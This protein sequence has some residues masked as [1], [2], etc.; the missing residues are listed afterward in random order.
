MMMSSPT[1]EQRE[2]IN[3]DNSNILV[4][5]GAGSGKTFVLKER[6]LRL[7][8]TKTTVDK[9][10]I[11]TFTKNAAAEMKE[12]IRKIILE[13]D[14][15]K[16]QL[17]LVDSAYITTFD[18]FA[19]SIVKKYNYLLNI[20][21]DFGII[22]ANIV[23]V[24]L[25]K[26]IDDIF[27][28]YYDKDDEE[29]KEL[30]T[31]YCYKNDKDLKESIISMYN[32]LLN[33]IDRDEYLDKYIE[34][35]FSDNYINSLMEE[36][37]NNIFNRIEKL[38]PLYDELLELTIKDTAKESNYNRFENIKN[39]TTFDELLES[40]S[41]PIARANKGWYEDGYK[42]IKASIDN[43]EKKIKEELLHN[44]NE[45]M[46]LYKDTLIPTKVIIDILKELDKRIVKFK[47]EHN[48]YEF[49][50]IALKAI[51]LVKNHPSVRE[52]IKNNTYEIMI[53]EY[54]DTNDIQETFISYIQNNN[55]YMVGD[56]KQSIYRF[57]NANPYIFKNKYDNY[58]H[59]EGGYKIDL[60]K[61][62][63]SREEVINNINNLFSIIM[64]DECGG[65][66]Y[67]ASH[68]MKYGQV[69]YSSNKMNNYDYNFELYNYEMDK[70][71]YP[72]ITKDEIEAF[73]I[74]DDIKK[75]LDRKETI[76]VEENKKN[77]S[78]EATYKDFAI[79]VDKSTNFDT[80]KKI[81]EYKGIPATIYKDVNIKEDDEVFILKNLISLLVH[82]KDNN[83]DYEFRHAFMSIGRSYIY[84]IDDATLFD[85]FRDKT[86]KETELYTKCLELSNMLDGLSNKEILTKLIDEFD[87]IN[88]LVTVGDIKDRTI[89]L[90]YFIE[91]ASSLNDFGYDIYQ[92]NDYF[93][94]V[95]NSDNPIQIPGKN[96]DANA[97]KIM[98]IHGSKGLEF[99]YVYM[100]YL[101]SQFKGRNHTRYIM[102]N[103][104]KY[105]ILLP[106]SKDEVIDNTFVYNLNDNYELKEEISEKIRLL[107]V[108]ITR[109]RE[110]FI[111]IN[112]Y[113]DK[114]EPVDPNLV[115][116]DDIFN[117][118]SFK[119][120]ITLLRNYYSKYQ[121]DIDLS[122]LGLTKDYNNSEASASKNNI[123]ESDIKINIVDNNIEYKIL[124]NKHFSKQ[125]SKVIDKQFKDTLDFGTFMHYC[126]EVYNF[127]DDNLDELEIPESNKEY[128]RN[129]LKHDEVKDIKNA[130]IY[131]EHEIRFNKDDSI[132]HGFIDL[133]VEYDDHF[134]I[135][136]YKTSSI[137]SPEYKEQLSGY[138]DY[139]E[140][141]YN[142]PCNIYLYSI[143]KDIFKKL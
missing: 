43:V 118:K 128:I 5:A 89:K 126:F 139:I 120:I 26:I 13:N 50:D 75:R 116:A 95:I 15:V 2:A 9:L 56:V 54:Q 134:D 10:I 29:F 137:D 117:C 68:A 31:K 41:T 113:K 44:E 1:E 23:K 30:L 28:E 121:V 16:D 138:K 102:S 86:F 24:E 110:K 87:I 81:L 119:D 18:S 3:K 42:P 104:S 74:A 101:Q 97:V 84:K 70:E 12:R 33:I 61:N 71:A 7:V 65:A 35:H 83:L 21:K 22:D 143:K 82:I 6:V 129:F 124:D 58:S 51:E 36:Y 78:R 94:T 108:A 8:S 141:Q 131:K 133:L 142:K 73:I 91:Q 136:D 40:L 130:N 19:N 69:D 38:Y 20:P 27:N 32:T 100:P 93:N 115:I 52:E 112:S 48:S 49:N 37:S 122:T 85:I 105:G 125:L 45:F 67:K 96:A 17:D 103:N 62:F 99:P 88:K 80:L 47:E 123:D 114:I 77:V 140:S 111:L 109:A 64:S 55:V 14:E 4:S 25:N 46:R 72:K 135:I 63:R 57:R 76:M 39:S 106:Y 98:T 79:L 92:L 11:L 90:E 132:F 59:N 60:T 66:N 53:D 34:T 107:Y 127:N